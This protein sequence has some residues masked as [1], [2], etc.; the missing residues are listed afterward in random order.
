MTPQDVVTEA[1]SWLGTP[2]HHQAAVKR[3]GTDCLGLVRGVY[4]TL[5]G[6]EPETPPPYGPE[7]GDYGN[8]ELMLEAATR[9]LVPRLLASPGQVLGPIHRSWSTGDV[10]VFRART[11]AVAKHCGISSGNGLMVHA[12]SGIG[13]VETDVGVW[14]TRIAG[15]FSFPGV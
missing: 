3:A 11:G 9:H 12:Y 7:W 1:R 10:L 14:G 13:V 8:E 5:Y 6:T 4:A 2:Y 15:V